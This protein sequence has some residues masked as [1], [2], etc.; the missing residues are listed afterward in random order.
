MSTVVQACITE[1]ELTG[2]EL[3]D[4]NCLQIRHM[5]K[6]MHWGHHNTG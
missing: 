4:S 3:F 5:Y 6:V 1:T 2:P